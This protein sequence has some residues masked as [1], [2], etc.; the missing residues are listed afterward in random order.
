MGDA[1]IALE[2]AKDIKTEPFESK[3]WGMKVDVKSPSLKERSNLLI[4][5]SNDAGDLDQDKFPPMLI[6]ACCFE[7]GTDEKAFTT[8]DIDLISG[9]LGKE[10][11]K[12]LSVCMKLGGF[13][14]AEKVK[15]D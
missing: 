3:L 7:P 9:K 8:E 14:A 2:K 5:A 12:L 13:E 4:N 1:R 6:I 10:M 15:N 11:Q